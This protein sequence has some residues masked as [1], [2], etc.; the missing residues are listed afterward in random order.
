MFCSSHFS[1]LV[2]FGDEVSQVQKYYIIF[3]YTFARQ[4]GK[5]WKE[6]HATKVTKNTKYQKKKYGMNETKV[7]F[8]DGELKSNRR[9]PCSCLN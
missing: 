1:F 3:V 9:Q 6:T 8:L 4:D 5:K 7:T 2:T